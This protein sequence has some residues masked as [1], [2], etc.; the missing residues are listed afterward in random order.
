MDA[1]SFGL[2]TYPLGGRVLFANAVRFSIISEIIIDCGQSDSQVPQS[3]QSAGAFPA[4][5]REIG[6]RENGFDDSA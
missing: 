3:T 2:F 1:A 4:G 6:M 5:W